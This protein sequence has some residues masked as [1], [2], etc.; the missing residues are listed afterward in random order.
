LDEDTA[1]EVVTAVT[2]LAC[3]ESE[4]KLVV[5]EPYTKCT[6]EEVDDDTIVCDRGCVA[7]DLPQPPGDGDI[8][9]LVEACPSNPT[10]KSRSRYFA[11]VGL[12][13]CNIDTDTVGQYKV[14][15]C[16]ESSAGSSSR[17]C[18][19]RKITVSPDCG[20]EKVCADGLTCSTDGSCVSD[21][22]SGGLTGDEPEEIR[23]PPVLNLLGD[24]FFKLK[25]GKT[26]R[27]CD[28]NDPD[29]QY[30]LD[31]PCDPGVVATDHDFNDVI[32]D[33]SDKV[34]VCPPMNCI[35]KGVGCNGFEFYGHAKGKPGEELQCGSINSMAAVGTLIELYYVVKDYTHPGE[36]GVTTAIR[37][38]TI[39]EPCD[40]PDAVFCEETRDC[41]LVPCDQRDTV[42]PQEKEDRPPKVQLKGDALMRVGYGEPMEQNLLFCRTLEEK[43]CG[44]LAV[45]EVNGV[46]TVAADRILLSSG[47][48]ASDAM[49]GK[50]LPGAYSFKYQAFDDAGQESNVARRIVIVEQRATVDVKLDLPLAGATDMVAAQAVAEDY[51]ANSFDNHLTQLYIQAFV[52]AYGEADSSITTSTVKITAVE[53]VEDLA[54]SF[55][56]LL[57]LQISVSSTVVETVGSS[58]SSE[59]LTPTPTPGPV[60]R[61]L[62]DQMEQHQHETRRLL[63]QEAQPLSAKLNS[64]LS[65]VTSDGGGEAF[66][67]AVQ[68]K[69]AEAGVEVDVPE[70]NEAPESV[71]TTPEVDILGGLVSTLVASLESYEEQRLSL[72]FRLTVLLGQVSEVSGD[73]HTQTNTAVD[74]RFK[75]EFQNLLR[76]FDSVTN[77][78]SGNLTEVLR[79]FDL[80]LAQQLALNSALSSTMEDL[81]EG[82]ANQA[83]FLKELSTRQSFIESVIGPEYTETGEPMPCP[84]ALSFGKHD[85]SFVIA[86]QVNAAE[87]SRRRLLVSGGGR[88]GISFEETEELFIENEAEYFGY[89]IVAGL[90]DTSLWDRASASAMVRNRYIGGPDRNKV[91]GGLFLHQTRQ[92]VNTSYCDKSTLGPFNGALPGA[93]FTTLS[94]DC[95]QR[96]FLKNLDDNGT[97]F[98]AWEVTI[99]DP[100]HPYG[101]DPVW[102]RSS[103]LFQVGMAGNEGN[104]Y[105]MTPADDN[106]EFNKLAG[107]MYTH[108]PREVPG[109]SQLGFPIYVDTSLD[110]IRLASLLVYVE[111]SNYMDRRSN[112]MTVQMSVYNAEAKVFGYG[113]ADIT[114]NING[115]WLQSFVFNGLPALDYDLSG[116]SGQARVLSDNLAVVCLVGYLLWYLLTVFSHPHFSVMAHNAMKWWI[117]AALI[118]AMAA[119]L[120]VYYTY[121]NGMLVFMAASQ[122]E[123]Y[124]A[125]GFSPARLLLPAKVDMAVYN[126]TDAVEVNATLS[127][128]GKPGDWASLPGGAGRWELPDNTTGLQEY[129]EMMA[130]MDHLSDQQALY[131]AMQGIV[132]LVMMFRMLHLWN[133]QD[134]V[135]TVTRTLFQVIP[136]L[137]EFT[138]VLVVL[139]VLYASYGVI[140]AGSHVNHYTNLQDAFYSLFV[141]I[142]AGDGGGMHEF[143]HRPGAEYLA[144][145]QVNIDF[146]YFSVW[147]FFF[148]TLTSYLLG[149]IGFALAYE[150]QVSDSGNAPVDEIKPFFAEAWQMLRKRL[151]SNRGIVETTLSKLHMDSGYELDFTEVLRQRLELDK[152]DAVMSVVALENGVL[153]DHRDLEELLL[154]A[155]NYSVAKRAHQPPLI[156]RNHSLLK[157]K[158]APE[159]IDSILSAINVIMH[160]YGKHHNVDPEWVEDMLANQQY[161]MYNAVLSSVKVILDAAE[162]QFIEQ[163]SEVEELQRQSNELSEIAVALGGAAMRPYDGG[164]TQERKAAARELKE[165]KE[166][167]PSSAIEP[168]E[169]EDD[170]DTRMSAIG[171]YSSS[172]NVKPPKKGKDYELLIESGPAPPARSGSGGM[173]GRMKQM[174]SGDKQ[175]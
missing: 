69:A 111:D 167:G 120:V 8:S 71:T 28:W 22:D 79:S 153:L 44:A 92:S 121:V 66:A 106:L 141:L 45:A 168:Q 97:T 112:G 5:G 39:E 122:Y 1:T 137:G 74:S 21:L 16:V 139:M 129:G 174:L 155:H 101:S 138:L 147:I 135:G 145:E 43:E 143:A 41:S 172:D 86:Y 158:T 49:A 133:F 85:F 150:K 163:V 53:A 80:L 110:E 149:Y 59:T 18:K 96:E 76:N 35:S 54:R 128:D 94:A 78:Q 10:K 40:D 56:L 87:E 113:K 31:N 23:E 152:D 29:D 20:L 104:Y 95:R 130:S 38:I 136:E 11:D 12:K 108:F 60:R 103:Q 82:L 65:A 19:E 25:R 100:V 151:P 166:T 169:K 127:A 61:L 175:H 131:G 170:S 123:V 47:C 119:A 114:R 91:L 93:K 90:E 162:W 51:R 146:W 46:A 36:V 14:V 102:V 9:N 156:E 105:N 160:N 126:G 159:S 17:I 4:V 132:L 144:V 50:C 75:E 173:F 116:F 157:K 88:G 6:K 161:E 68:S 37:S 84:Q 34:A 30:S 98:D 24:E 27:K 148:F 62:S 73:G 3:G 63:L 72:A 7:K 13:Y 32:I 118:A 57:T 48:L 109:K 125:I 52:E 134:Q 2:T 115:A 164:F 64:V 140:V 117:D 33:I 142:V 107:S 89:R 83:A 124:D 58:S 171:S 42:I 165:L 99:G 77:Q 70:L 154:C 67:N 26:Y 15:F 81:Q 55:K